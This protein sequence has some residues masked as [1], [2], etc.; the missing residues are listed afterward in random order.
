MYPA[1]I[2]DKYQNQGVKPSEGQEAAFVLLVVLASGQERVDF[3]LHVL[4]TVLC[5]GKQER[6]QAK[7]LK[8]GADAKT[9]EE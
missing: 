7:D 5:E 2:G 3:S 9:V 4:T 8:T 1:Q 6:T